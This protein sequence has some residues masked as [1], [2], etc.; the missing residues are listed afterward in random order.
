V[1]R[2][3]LTAVFTVAFAALLVGLV[4][5]IG[6]VVGSSVREQALR[7]A[8]D[9]TSAMAALS[10]QAAQTADDEQDLASLLRGYA[11]AVP[12]VEQLALRDIDGR[13]FA[14]T[15][16]IAARLLTAP[17]VARSGQARA[18]RAGPLIVVD[19]RL[20]EVAGLPAG[21]VLTAVLSDDEV[22]ATVDRELRRSYLILGGAALLLYLALL[23]LVI[24]ASRAVASST[25][26]R[27]RRPLA[28]LRSALREGRFE[29]HYQPVV[30]I[31]GSATG[32]W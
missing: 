23:P 17:Q 1:P 30:P 13:P 10:V 9:T 15:G 11:R 27:D 8:A 29:L 24:R 4:L 26:H 32:G 12:D 28:E 16:P 21:T 7:S 31:G 14:T 20:G 6:H 18:R 3:N 25:E 19:V 22:T 2:S 5:L